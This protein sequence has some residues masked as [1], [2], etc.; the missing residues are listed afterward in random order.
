LLNHKKYYLQKGQKI[1]ELVNDQLLAGKHSVNWNGE[2]GSGKKVGSGLYLYKL[3]INDET[4]IIKKCMLL[5]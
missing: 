1:K 2:D 5:K 3:K 4:A